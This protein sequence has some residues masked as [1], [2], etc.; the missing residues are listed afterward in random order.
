M[1]KVAVICMIYIV[2]PAN[3]GNL[4][5]FV[6]RFRGQCSANARTRS[7]NKKLL[8]LMVILLLLYLI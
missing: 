4:V 7:G 6:K 8:H 1:G 2:S 3:A 5:S